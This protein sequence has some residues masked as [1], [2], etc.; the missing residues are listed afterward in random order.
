[1]DGSLLQYYVRPH[2]ELLSLQLF[3]VLY[4]IDVYSTPLLA[5][6]RRHVF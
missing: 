1:M 3:E 5:V 6:T 2:V 4:T